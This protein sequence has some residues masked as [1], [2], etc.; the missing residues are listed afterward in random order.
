MKRKNKEDV[1]CVKPHIIKPPLEKI[2]III[3]IRLY[4]HKNR[5]ISIKSGN[6]NN[7]NNN[8]HTQNSNNKNTNRMCVAKKANAK[9]LSYA[10]I[11]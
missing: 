1:V 6:N 2:C 10:H 9:F 11:L 4:S 5:F 3:S 7:N 8:K